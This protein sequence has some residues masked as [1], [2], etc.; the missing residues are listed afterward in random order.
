LYAART[1]AEAL[2]CRAAPRREACSNSSSVTAMDPSP[3][4]AK[5][6]QPKLDLGGEF[7]DL[8]QGAAAVFAQGSAASL[9]PVRMST[10]RSTMTTPTFRSITSWPRLSWCA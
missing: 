4:L 8:R 5:L 2:A 6:F 10:R 7:I 1:T 3:F 9:S